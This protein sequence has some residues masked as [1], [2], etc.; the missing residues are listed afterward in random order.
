MLLA[1]VAHLEIV[2]TVNL[3]REAALDEDGLVVRTSRP[4]GDDGLVRAGGRAVA[5]H[6]VGR[7]R[8]AQQAGENAA[9]ERL[10][11]DAATDGDGGVHLD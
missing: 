3:C 5:A 7:L 1:Q 8:A 6:P 11:R 4:D 10:Q 9:K 2:I